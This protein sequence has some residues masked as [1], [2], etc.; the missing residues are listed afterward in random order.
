MSKNI[1]IVGGGMSGLVA[2]RIL[3]DDPN[4]KITLIEK[5]NEFG[6]LYTSTQSESGYIFDHGSHTVLDT[7]VP[8]LDAI[9]FEDFKDDEW[10][11][12]SDSLK[13][14]VYFMGEHT[15]N[16]VCPDARKLPKDIYER[17][18]AEFL[19]LP[20]NT[21]EAQNLEEHL[22]STYG[23]TLSE[24]LFRPI[25][26]KFYKG[27]FKKLD[28]KMYKDFLPLGRIIMFDEETT[29]RLKTIPYYDNLIAWTDFK[30]GSSSINKYFSKEGG[31]AVWP[32]LVENK[33][34]SMNVDLRA[35]QGVVSM[36]KNGTQITNVT[37]ESGETLAC[38]EL[39][40]TVPAFMLLQTAKIDIPSA[41][42]P[43][44]LFSSVFNF[45]FDQPFLKD[46][47]WVFNYDKNM[48][49]FRVTLY[50]NLTAG[51]PTAAPHHVT[52]ESLNS[53]PL[54]EP[55]VLFDEL[56]QELV[57]M[58]FVSPNAKIIEKFCYNAQGPRPIP[59][60]A[61]KKAQAE[62][63]ALVKS[64]LSNVTLYGRA[65]GNHFMNPLLREIWFD[66]KGT[67]ADP[68]QRPI[69]RAVA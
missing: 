13:E 49:T 1:V 28:P 48:K 59:T 60:I 62:Q 53:Q 20:E 42:K 34:R 69:A 36:N 38:D 15:P 31:V 68:H 40:W 8:E 30:N 16:S 65:N 33:V 61:Y 55:A 26:E 2:A 18:V 64:E 67:Q 24:N 14:T 10:E 7:G 6:G 57:T 19:N 56:H 12:I 32:R 22:Y 23:E 39:I 41:E 54:K 9:L 5:S 45:V 47:H 52:V 66:I 51:G 50:P 25:I 37:L 46:D 63:I 17:A 21:T 58:G 11:I 3:A 27:D 35:E 29:A 43:D 44:M 4:N